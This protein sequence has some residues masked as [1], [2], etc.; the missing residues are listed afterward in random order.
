MNEAPLKARS[1]NQ[2]QILHEQFPGDCCLCK[3]EEK[4]KQVEGVL[5]EKAWLPEVQDLCQTSKEFAMAY[6]FAE[7]KHSGQ[8]D[9][10]KKPYFLFHV[11]QVTNIL[12]NV[13][14]DIPILQAALLHDTIEDTDTTYDEL[15]TIFGHKVADLVM[16]VTHEGSKEK[17][18]YFF[19]RLH[20]KEGI[21]IKFADR[22]SNLSRMQS[23]S[24][25]RQTHY[26]KKSKFWKTTE[27]E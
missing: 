23:W 9:D 3:A 1:I 22:L 25:D 19:P 18:G 12:V 5:A 24:E 14:R 4:I 20:S 21:L 7:I 2:H 15:K 6:E 26:I 13:T 10:N 17:K 11:L 16:E 8:L 27:T